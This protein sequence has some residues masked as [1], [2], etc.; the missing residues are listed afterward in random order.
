MLGEILGTAMAIMETDSAVTKRVK[1]DYNEMSEQAFFNK[2]SGT[3]DQ[4]AR[5]VEKYGDPYMNSPMAKLAKSLF[6]KR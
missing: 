3:K 5:R 4:Y 6:G 1:N 2:Y